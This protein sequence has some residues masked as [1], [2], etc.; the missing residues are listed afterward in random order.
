MPG[1]VIEYVERVILFG[2]GGMFPRWKALYLKLE[3]LLVFDVDQDCIICICIFV[4]NDWFKILGENILLEILINVENRTPFLVWIILLIL[5]RFE[6][7]LVL[8]PVQEEVEDLH[9]KFSLESLSN[10]QNHNYEKKLY[11]I[12]FNISF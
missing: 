2:I 4:H 7:L 1:S 6:K 9:N 10:I 5:R 3:I 12:K 8:F 11:R